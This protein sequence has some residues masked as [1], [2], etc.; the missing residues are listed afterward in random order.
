MITKVQLLP[1][2]E[3]TA[4]TTW[5]RI[6]F[7]LLVLVP[8]LGLYEFT[9]HLHHAG[10]AFQFAFE[11]SLP[12]Y[13]WTAPVYQSIYVVAVGAPWIARTRRDLRRLTISAWLAIVLVFPIY[14]VMPSSAPRRP[15]EVTNWLTR[16][17]HWERST[18]PPTQAFPSFHVLWVIFLA[19]LL[20][21][22]W[23]GSAYAAAVAVSCIT[24]GMHYIPDVLASVAIAPFLAAPGWVWN[25]VRT[26]WR[27]RTD[28]SGREAF[29]RWALAPDRSLRARAR[30]VRVPVSCTLRPES[31]S[32]LDSAE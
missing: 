11:D 9:A 10:T 7:V 26:A 15:L 22:A 17:L 23:L 27:R 3:D 14:W 13:P 28:R 24:T 31:P 1:R 18:Y 32:E 8:W 19:R 20:R 29:P 6:R 12:I 21:P 2:D 25:C 4:L 5:E 16:I 30:R